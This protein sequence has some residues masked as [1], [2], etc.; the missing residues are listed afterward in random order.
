MLFRKLYY[1]IQA[2]VLIASIF[3][4]KLS[5]EHFNIYCFVYNFEKAQQEN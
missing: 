3:S 1:T 4:S 2:E 5:K